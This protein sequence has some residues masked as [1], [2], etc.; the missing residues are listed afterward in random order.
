MGVVGVGVL[1]T[2]LAL[3]TLREDLPVV[4]RRERLM[5]VRRD[6][7]NSTSMVRVEISRREIESALK[8]CRCVVSSTTRRLIRGISGAVTPVARRI[9]DGETTISAA[10]DL[11]AG[12]LVRY[13]SIL[14]V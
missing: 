6:R 7:I 12:S 4:L 8:I 10:T 3:T 9:S 2:L 13:V 14:I 11:G 5:V 1:S